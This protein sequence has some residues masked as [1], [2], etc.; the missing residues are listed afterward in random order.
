MSKIA[1]YVIEPGKKKKVIGGFFLHLGLLPVPSLIAQQ[2][3]PS[4]CE[5][6]AYCTPE[7][8]SASYG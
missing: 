2:N 7:P 6:R 5:Y 4:L 8:V 3:I 1:L